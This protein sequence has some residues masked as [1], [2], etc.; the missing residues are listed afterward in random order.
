MGFMD[1]EIPT[2]KQE[3]DL[4]FDSYIK[5]TRGPMRQLKEKFRLSDKKFDKFKSKT[6]VLMAFKL[7]IGEVREF[8]IYLENQLLGSRKFLVYI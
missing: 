6:S 1:I 3:Q 2:A 8:Q 4:L 7:R 5:K